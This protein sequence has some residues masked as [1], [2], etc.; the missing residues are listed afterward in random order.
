MR[1]SL[2][3]GRRLGYLCVGTASAMTGYTP[4]QNSHPPNPVLCA[5]LTHASHLRMGGVTG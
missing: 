5:R 4:A 3:A 2:R 1:L